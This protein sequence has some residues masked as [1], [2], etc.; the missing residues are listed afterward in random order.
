MTVSPRMHLLQRMMGE[1]MCRQKLCDSVFPKDCRLR[2]PTYLSTWLDL[3]WGVGLAL[4]MD[5]EV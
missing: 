4:Y 5:T 3:G 1:H 2:S